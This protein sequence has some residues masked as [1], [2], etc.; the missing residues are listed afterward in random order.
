MKLERC[1]STDLGQC[2]Y[3]VKLRQSVKA[4]KVRQS[5]QST[6][7]KAVLVVS[8]LRLLSKSF[9]RMH[10]AS[11]CLQQRI[12]RR[13]PLLFEMYNGDRNGQER[14]LTFDA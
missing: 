9:S 8:M 14:R 7:F 12:C 5:N 3:F 1:Q 4:A 13:T 2:V 10:G 11:C 6:S